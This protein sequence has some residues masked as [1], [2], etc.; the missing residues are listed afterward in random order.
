MEAAVKYTVLSF[1][2]G[3]FVALGLIAG[4]SIIYGRSIAEINAAFALSL[5]ILGKFLLLGLV[6]CIIGIII[7]WYLNE[8]SSE[9]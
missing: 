8:V 1:V 5:G 3:I 9:S 7:G 2:L 4:P 6:F